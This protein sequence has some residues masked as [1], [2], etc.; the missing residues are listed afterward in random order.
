M[1]MS[2]SSAAKAVALRNKSAQGGISRRFET[3][4]AKQCF[5][6]LFEITLYRELM[7]QLWKLAHPSMVCSTTKTFLLGMHTLHVWMLWS[8]STWITCFA[9]G[10]YTGASILETL[11]TWAA[12]TLWV[13]P[14][15]RFPTTRF[16]TTCSI[17]WL[18][19]VDLTLNSLHHIF[20]GI[21][22]VGRQL[23]R[24]KRSGGC[25][26]LIGRHIYCATT[27][28]RL[29]HPKLKK[30][31]W[32]DRGSGN[33]WQVLQS[34]IPSFETCCLVFRRAL[35]SFL[36]SC[37]FPNQIVLLTVRT[38]GSSNVRNL[39]KVREIP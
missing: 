9:F 5:C 38:F 12:P 7:L 28:R 30:K 1:P 21:I 15:V 26:E 32:V 8:S 22:H 35:F 19:R 17:H 6:R 20:E 37:R 25:V 3:N 24:N 31:S 34:N 10:R 18:G 27:D 14:F 33:F 16:P 36:N 2:I 23:R 29:D 13:P 39:L 11:A 4:I